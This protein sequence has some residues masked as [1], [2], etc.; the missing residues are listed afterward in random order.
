[1]RKDGNGSTSLVI[2]DRAAGR[3]MMLNRHAGGYVRKV[4]VNLGITFPKL[5]EH[6]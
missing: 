6:K 5:F 2:F 1:M 3:P 4:A